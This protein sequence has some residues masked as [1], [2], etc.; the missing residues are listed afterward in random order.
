MF[1]RC[2]A[3]HTVHPLNAA[4]LAQGGGKYRCAKC[5][6]V[7]NALEALFDE[8]PDASQAGAPPGQLPELGGSLALGPFNPAVASTD[9]VMPEAGP[10]AATESGSPGRKYLLRISW[11]AAALALAAVIGLGFAD[12][13]QRPVLDHPLVQT[14]LIKLGVKQTPAVAPFRDREQIE[15]LSRE[16]KPHRLRPGV[17]LLTATIV[18]RAPR[19][20]SY[21]DID[22]TLLDSRGRR[23]TRQ[24]FS[25]GDYL[26]RSS[27][28]RSGMTPNAYLTFSLEMLDPGQEAAGF[29]LQFR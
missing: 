13:F 3:C 9:G 14:A 29:E 23:L 18:N 10:D 19:S 6:K 11:I 26:S 17:L 21:P 27:E 22:V 2:Q 8:W 1:T 4:L 25:P 16:L 12:F 24:L 7:G 20:Q 5:K 15:L 28:L